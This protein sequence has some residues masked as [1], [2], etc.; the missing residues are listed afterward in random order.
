[1]PKYGR[2]MQCVAVGNFRGRGAQDMG[3]TIEKVSFR[4]LETTVSRVAGDVLY[5]ELVPPGA[6]PRVVA[7]EHVIPSRIVDFVEAHADLVVHLHDEVVRRYAGA[8][9]HV[10]RYRTGD[11]AYVLGR[12]FVLEV[13]P[14]KNG[15]YKKAARG[16]MTIAAAPDLDVSCLYLSVATMGS[17][18]QGRE[19]FL[20]WAAPVFLAEATSR[21]HECI[22]REREVLAPLADACVRDRELRDAWASID[23]GNGT[24]WL[25]RRLIAY[26]PECISYAVMVAAARVCLPEATPLE[27]RSLVE[28]GCPSWSRAKDILSEGASPYARQ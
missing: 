9:A 8:V 15:S 23:M 10:C 14:T 1:M 26:P 21:V 3:E 5:M 24:I 2:G 25:S 7:G 13:L 28:T 20:A 12:P 17:Y 6:V 18:D 16:R 27:R 22:S 11:V 4:G 19:A